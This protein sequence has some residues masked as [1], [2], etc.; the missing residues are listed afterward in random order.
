MKGQ[1]HLTLEEKRRQ[2]KNEEKQQQQKAIKNQRKK[3][4]LGKKN[5]EKKEKKKEEEKKKRKRKKKITAYSLPS[6]RE[7]S[8][9]P[10]A[11]DRRAL[12]ITGDT[13][14]PATVFRLRSALR[15]S[16][17]I[18]SL[19]VQTLSLATMVQ[20]CKHMLFLVR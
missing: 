11:L 16:L 2:L 13:R 5:K 18:K 17:I 6:L 15:L 19:V 12:G 7:R 8:E 4:N 3:K 1:T 14:C 10:G 9:T 20:H